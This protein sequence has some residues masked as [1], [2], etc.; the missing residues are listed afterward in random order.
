MDAGCLAALP[1]VNEKMQHPFIMI[2]L[3]TIIAVLPSIRR[4]TDHLFRN[5]WRLCG[6]C[7]GVCDNSVEVMSR[8]CRSYVG[9][10]ENSV[11]LCRGY[12]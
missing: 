10:C 6:S 8:L 5:V 1:A 3:S 4:A 2:R 7:V 12:V 11:R 9:L